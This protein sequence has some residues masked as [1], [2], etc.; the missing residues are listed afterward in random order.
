MSFVHGILHSQSFPF[1]MS[2]QEAAKQ[3]V[4]T[5]VH[6]DHAPWRKHEIRSPSE[7]TD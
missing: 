6:F 7:H 4:I 3:G 2:L 5:A 1:A